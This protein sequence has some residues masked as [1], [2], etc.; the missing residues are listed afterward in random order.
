[1][2]AESGAGGGSSAQ[3]PP[4]FA[5]L[6]ESEDVPPVAEGDADGDDDWSRRLCVLAE[7]SHLTASTAEPAE[8]STRGIGTPLAMHALRAAAALQLARR[9][10]DG[11]GHN[12]LWLLTEMAADYIRAIGEQLSRAPP[13]ARPTTSLS[14]A[15]PLVARLQRFTGMRRVAEWR[16]LRPI[17]SLRFEPLGQAAVAQLAQHRQPVIG[18]TPLPRGIE[19]LYGAIRG[20]WQYKLTAAGRAAH[21][22]AGVADTP[23][24][25]AA[26][27]DN[28]QL[29][30]VV[31]L[32]KRQRLVADSWLIGRALRHTAG[33][34]VLLPGTPVT[35]IAPK[36]PADGAE[37]AAPAAKRRKPTASS[38]SQAGQHSQQQAQHSEVPPGPAV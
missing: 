21:A 25:A 16:A 2:Q 30:E 8:I 35:E 14:H 4:P 10:A 13:P 20:A 15:A 19:A 34:P 3:P 5:L 12:A 18:G 24:A 31:G 11:L 9:G 22:L 28:S 38:A 29:V 36:Q 1:M 17:F 32:G 23:A 27:N 6:D 26:T 37:Q 7:A 33:A